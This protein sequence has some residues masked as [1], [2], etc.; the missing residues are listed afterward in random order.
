MEFMILGNANGVTG[1]S[2]PPSRR[3]MQQEGEEVWKGGEEV[4]D[5]SEGG[6]EGRGNRSAKPTSNEHGLGRKSECT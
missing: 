1:C 6:S 4:E 5:R 2:G 3:L